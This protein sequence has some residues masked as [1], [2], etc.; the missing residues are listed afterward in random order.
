V[1]YGNKMMKK[2]KEK[3]VGISLNKPENLVLEDLIKPDIP[4]FVPMRRDDGS[5]SWSMKT[6]K[7]IIKH[8]PALYYFIHVLLD[9]QH[10][11]VET[12]RCLY[13]KDL[14]EMF[15]RDIEPV[16]SKNYFRFIWGILNSLQVIEYL[17]DNKPNKYK[18][19][20]KAY[21]FRFRAKYSATPVTEHQVLYKE[22]TVKKINFKW[23]V[24]N[25][26]E[27]VKVDLSRITGN[28]Q[29]LHQY[30]ALH[31][32]R[33]DADAASKHSKGLLDTGQINIKQYNSY[34]ISINNIRNG[35]VKVTHSIS[36]NRFYTPVTEMPREL[37]KF[38]YDNEGNSLIELD[39]SSF[40]AYAVYKLINSFTPEYDSDYK[41]I[42][43]EIEVELYRRLLAGG[44]FY[45]SFKGVF[46]PDQE[47]DRDQ[48]KDIVLK[49]WFN[50]RLT[51]RNK[52]RKHML[53]QL[54]RISEV[55]DCLKVE[56]YQNFSNTTMKME[57]ELV[58]DI[59][60]K[61][62]IDLHPDAILYTI[63]DS[64][65]VEQ[66]YAAQLQSLMQEEGGKYFN[67]NCIVKTK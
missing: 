67:I 65:L 9:R 48:I 30:N 22:S 64:F 52:Y 43:Y 50:G 57:S 10:S 23:G 46:F 58:N 19:S 29:L 16:K 62:F 17:D 28:K 34:Q 13:N 1:Y 53:K 56:K 37:R 20:A 61:K 32:I 14:I 60:Y 15:S 3:Y 49:F 59:I 51:S 31:N 11:D 25:R 42:Q 63:F 18:K 24:C 35:R 7:Q 40:N 54:P 8:I 36:C 33:F 44:D 38:I 5:S 12:L 4:F 45:R 41:K 55:I 47:L 27:T 2:Q 6:G 21:Y 26:K 39:F 66:K